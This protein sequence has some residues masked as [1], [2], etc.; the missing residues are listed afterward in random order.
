MLDTAL[1]FDLNLLQTD[2]SYF[3]SGSSRPAKAPPSSKVAKPSTPNPMSTIPADLVNPHDLKKPPSARAIPGSSAL[4]EGNNVESLDLQ[5][6]TSVASRSAQKRPALP[7]HEPRPPP[8]NRPPR[9]P[10]TNGEGSKPRPRPPPPKRD[11][12]G[13]NLFIPK[14]VC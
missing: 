7:E 10:Q 1:A 9:P 11:K 2:V 6:P 12:G 13:P 8:A 4:N 14:K 5:T 3:T